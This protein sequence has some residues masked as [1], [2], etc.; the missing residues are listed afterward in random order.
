MPTPDE[1]G[2]EGGSSEQPSN[3]IPFPS[4]ENNRGLSERL[5]KAEKDLFEEIPG[6]IMRILRQLRK[7]GSLD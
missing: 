6:R 5:K 3:V 7:S 4:P 2:M 1:S